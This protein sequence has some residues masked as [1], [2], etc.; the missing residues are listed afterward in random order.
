MAPLIAEWPRG[1]FI[2]KRRSP[3]EWATN[4]RRR[5][6]MVSPGITPTPP[7]TTRVGIPSVCDSTV[8][9]TRTDLMAGSFGSVTDCYHL[10]RSRRRPASAQAGGQRAL[11]GRPH[12][13]LLLRQQR[14]ARWPA[15]AA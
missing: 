2:R 7:V 5:S 1:S 3:S 8:W 15:G 6:A 12:G 14:H 4:Q 10:V 13:G 9:I 11:G